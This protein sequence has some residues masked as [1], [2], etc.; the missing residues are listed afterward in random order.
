MQSAA[1]AP[2]GP[3]FEPVSPDD[4]DQLTTLTNLEGTFFVS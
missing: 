1:P 2:S 4:N 3:Q